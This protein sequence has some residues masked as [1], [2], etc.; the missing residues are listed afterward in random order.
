MKVV[1]YPQ[2]AAYDNA[3][4]PYRYGGNPPQSEDNQDGWGEWIALDLAE[5]SLPPKPQCRLSLTP[6]QVISKP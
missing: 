5:G 2:P 4:Q 6:F 3:D 1:A